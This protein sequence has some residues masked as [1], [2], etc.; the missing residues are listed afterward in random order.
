MGKFNFVFAFNCGKKWFNLQSH[1]N[2]NAVNDMSNLIL[3]IANIVADDGRAVYCKFNEF[4]NASDKIHL[5]Y[6]CNTIVK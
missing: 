1:K 5:Y 2:K 6:C 4:S 3:K